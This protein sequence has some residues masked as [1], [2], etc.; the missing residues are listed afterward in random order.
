[1]PSGMTQ[2]AR[3]NPHR[4]RLAFVKALKSR[5][6]VRASVLYTPGAGKWDD[7]YCAWLEGVGGTSKGGLGKDGGDM[8]RKSQSMLAAAA[9]PERCDRMPILRT[10]EMS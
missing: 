4:K 6:P 9:W 8:A 3:D 10:S 7:P 1:M 5:V 2:T